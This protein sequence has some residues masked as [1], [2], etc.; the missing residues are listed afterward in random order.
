M[1]LTPIPEAGAS[2]ESAQALHILGEYLELAL[3][4]GGALI[5]PEPVAGAVNDVV[6]AVEEHGHPADTPLAHG[7]LESRMAHGVAGP[8]PLGAGVERQ[9]AEQGGTKL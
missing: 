6:Q 5:P 1:A 4:V 3:D 9:L 7:D 8:Q 2:D